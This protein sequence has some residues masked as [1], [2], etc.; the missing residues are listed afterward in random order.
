MLDERLIDVITEVFGLR[1]EEVTSE[2]SRENVA[3]WSSV[4]HLQLV[5]L[6]EETFGLRF[7][8]EEIPRLN[9]V[10][11]FQEVI[12]RMQESQLH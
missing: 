6:V 1:P 10:G 7:S 11:D 12:M 5:L 3:G 2:S 8:T 4:G 9:S